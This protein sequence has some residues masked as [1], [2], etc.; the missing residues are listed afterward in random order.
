MDKYIITEI[1]KEYLDSSDPYDSLLSSSEIESSEA[2]DLIIIASGL[3]LQGPIFLH[4][5][6]HRIEFSNNTGGLV[7]CSGHG[8]PP[9]EAVNIIIVQ[10]IRQHWETVICNYLPKPRIYISSRMEKIN[11]I[12][13]LN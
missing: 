12:E 8:S 6:P 13:T 9:P 2:T 11:I 4:E 10:D 3:D 5:P 1:M 7:E